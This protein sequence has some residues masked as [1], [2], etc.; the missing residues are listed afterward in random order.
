M[1]REAAAWAVLAVMAPVGAWWAR[2][3]LGPRMGDW[4]VEV[5][6]IVLRAHGLLAARL[7]LDR[8]AVRADQA[9]RSEFASGG[10]T[11]EMGRKANHGRDRAVH[12]LSL[13]TVSAC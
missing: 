11:I 2:P 1:P 3:A 12:S 9:T 10:G 6:R 5:R 7:A 8:S 4:A 13:S